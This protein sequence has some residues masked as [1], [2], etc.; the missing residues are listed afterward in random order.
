[1][2]DWDL[3]LIILCSLVIFLAAYTIA[4][5]NK[6]KFVLILFL[7][8]LFSFAGFNYHLRISNSVIP[9]SFAEIVYFSLVLVMGLAW[10]RNR[11]AVSAIGLEWPIRIYL[12]CALVGVFT[13]IYFDVSFGNII[14]ELKSYAVYIFYLYLI[15]FLMDNKEDVTKSLWAFIILSI[16]PLLYVLSNLRGLSAMEHGRAE[17]TQYWGPLNV[18]V[19]YISP[20]IFIAIALYL[21]TSRLIL[22]A[23]LLV[24]IIFCLYVL[25]YSETRSAW[26]SFSISSVIFV[27]LSKKTIYLGFTLI[28][29]VALIF[30]TD[31]TGKIKSIVKHRVEEEMIVRM[32]S[33][34]QDRLNR[35][36][37]AEKIFKAHPLIGSGWGGY[38]R[39]LG[40]G[41]V[42]S[43][44]S[45]GLPAWHNSFLEILSQLGILG[46]I[47]FYWVW[48]RI[49][50]LSYTAWREPNDSKD[51]LILGGLI[52]AV[53]CMF[54]YSFGEQQFYRVETASVSWFIIG[55]LVAHANY[56]NFRKLNAQ[57][58]F[59]G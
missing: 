11:E 38:L 34:L 51:K 41:Q 2:I 6:R 7:I 58:N 55:L 1:M 47:A 54:I 39:P 3:K 28:M 48:Y 26:I 52:S 32:D 15:P 8:V 30:F 23:S 49:F 35:W 37:I 24:F 36:E 21:T 22:K 53:L 25:L 46:I 45:R 40:D 59:R 17:L 10:L 43:V 16:I 18:F 5:W 13:A 20:M 56:L 12:L 57:D 44:S 42:S 50:K 19:G 4:D 9:T 31:S 33:S 27:F 14:T 29:L